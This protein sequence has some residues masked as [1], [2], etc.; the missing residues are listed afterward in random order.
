[1]HF[2]VM[3]PCSL[4]FLLMSFYIY[5]NYNGSR[6]LQ[7]SLTYE[8]MVFN[9]KLST[10]LNFVGLLHLLPEDI[11]K[12]DTAFEELHVDQ[13]DYPFACFVICLGFLIVLIIEQIVLLYVGSKAVTNS[14]LADPSGLQGTV[15]ILCL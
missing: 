3:R 7:Y 10:C 1:M 12:M 14:E 13:Q 11:E 4:D 2:L 5:F 8:H 15:H 6:L 9:S